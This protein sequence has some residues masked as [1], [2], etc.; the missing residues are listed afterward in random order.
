[1]LAQCPGF[2]PD[3]FLVAKQRLISVEIVVWCVTC[4]WVTTQIIANVFTPG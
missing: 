2:T 3:I 1:M 4:F